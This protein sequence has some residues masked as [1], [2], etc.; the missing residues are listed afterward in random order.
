[1]GARL[2]INSIFIANFEIIKFFKLI[3]IENGTVKIIVYGLQDFV[4]IAL[5]TYRIR[6]TLENL[7]YDCF[8]FT[9]I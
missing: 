2:D 4:T 8:T 9:R 7:P 5:E 1:M 3:V 6:F